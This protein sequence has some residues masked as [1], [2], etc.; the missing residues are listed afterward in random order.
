LP[1]HDTL[2][3]RFPDLLT[4]LVPRHP[5][6]GG[7]LAM[8]CG[9]RPHAR[10][11]EGAS[12]APDTAIYI[13]DTLGEMGLFYRLAPFCFVGGT[14]V[15]M[16][17]HNPLEPA[18]LHCAVLAGP[19]TANARSAFEAVLGAQG[20]GRVI[21]S[22]DIAREAARLIADPQAASA[23][24]DAAARGAASLSGAVERSAAILKTLFDARA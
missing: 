22:G 17:G 5:E 13:A 21:T 24:G 19:H 7:D 8:L 4:V 6:R 15:P 18:A 10:R 14:L 20:F 9:T 1:A 2:R 23:A 16:G 11:S 12:I 3:A